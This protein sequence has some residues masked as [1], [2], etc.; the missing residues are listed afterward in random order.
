MV[1]LD[2]L[3]LSSL[4]NMD[5]SEMK[6]CAKTYASNAKSYAKTLGARA[7]DQMR[8]MGSKKVMLAGRAVNPYVLG[9]AAVALIAGTAYFLLS[10]RSRQMQLAGMT[11]MEAQEYPVK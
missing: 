3:N 10:R 9:A 4:K 7:V 6:S 5:V 8:Y 11:E 2:R 1:M